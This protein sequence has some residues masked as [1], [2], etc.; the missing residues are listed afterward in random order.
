MTTSPNVDETIGNTYPLFHRNGAPMNHI[1]FEIF[2]LE[3]V[4][5]VDSLNGPQSYSIQLNTQN[6][7]DSRQFQQNVLQIGTPKAV[8]SQSQSAY[9]NWTAKT[10]SRL[11]VDYGELQ[12][13]VAIFQELLSFGD[14]TKG[15]CIR[16]EIG[17]TQISLMIIEMIGG[18]ILFQTTR[19]IDY[20]DVNGDHDVGLMPFISAELKIVGFANGSDCQFTKGKFMVNVITFGP[21]WW[22]A[23]GIDSGLVN[24]RLPGVVTLETSN[25]GSSIIS[26]AQ[27]ALGPNTPIWNSNEPD[28][29][30]SMC[31]VIEAF[32]QGD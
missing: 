32:P 22:D 5:C 26:M 14:F 23:V 20:T 12:L 29:E 31:Y 8:G 17:P 18:G 9:W 11:N 1:I 15:Q 25:F 30:V 2:P 27:T 28:G 19:D 7:D 24:G 10:D 21:L 4:E 3:P 6:P 16:L 13:N